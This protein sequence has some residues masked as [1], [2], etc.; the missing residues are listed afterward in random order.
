MAGLKPDFRR[1]LLRLPHSA[2]DYAAVALIADLAGLLGAN[3]IGTYVDDEDLRS[4]ADLPE[5]REFRAGIWQPLNSGQFES[6]LA[7]ATREAERRFM[8]S[9][10]LHRPS[11]RVVASSYAAEDEAGNNDIVVVIEPKSAIERATRQFSELLDDAFRSRSSI[12][13]V[14]SETRR[15]SG[16][17]VVVASGPDDPCISA[18]VAIAA[19]A[20]ERLVFIPVTCPMEALATALESARAAGVATTS[21]DAVFHQD[22]LLLPA[23][24]KAGLLITGRERMIRRRSR[25]RI[26]ALLVSSNLRFP[27]PDAGPDPRAG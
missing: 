8:Q 24:I 7:S 15:F 3:L 13:W 27:G 11:F 20:K 23:H 17:V 5:A 14:P 21:A 6:D 26:P 18:A 22:D 1:M 12:L 16:P 2:G 4:L 25:L 19:S 10:G 9:T